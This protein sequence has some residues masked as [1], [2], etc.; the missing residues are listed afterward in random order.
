M[1]TLLN[2]NRS[3]ANILRLQ[4]PWKRDTRAF[5]AGVRPGAQSHDRPGSPPVELQH[6][7]LDSLKSKVQTA[8]A[9]SPRTAPR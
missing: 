4:A 1:R 6:A 7:D 5:V 8:A 3:I 2:L 9:R